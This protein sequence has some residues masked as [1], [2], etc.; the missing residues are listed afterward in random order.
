MSAVADV[1]RPPVIR[2][3]VP[4]GYQGPLYYRLTRL[5]FEAGKKPFQELI[6]FKN[7][8]LAQRLGNTMTF[9]AAWRKAPQLCDAQGELL[10]DLRTPLAAK[11]KANARRWDEFSIGS[12]VFVSERIHGLIEAAAPGA[13]YFVPVDVTGHDG[14]IF[15]VYV[16]FCGVA[17]AR[18]LLDL[19]ANNIPHTR[20]D[21][22]SLEFRRPDWLDSDHFGYLDA[23]VVAGA[24]LLYDHLFGLVFVQHLTEQLGDCLPAGWAFV[25][26]GFV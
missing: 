21:S 8:R 4:P 5:S 16:F 18:T 6:T 1:S 24:P 7:S 12:L 15:R 26:M 22:G 14:G 9:Q 19:E 17:R 2:G 10:P 25:P 20:T 3:S 13:H 11:L 23:E